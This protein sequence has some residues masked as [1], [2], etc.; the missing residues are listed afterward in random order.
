MKLY[1]YAFSQIICRLLIE[2]VYNINRLH[3]NPNTAS[4]KKVVAKNYKR[5]GRERCEIKLG[6]Q[7]LPPAV[8]KIK[9]FDNDDKA[10][11]H[12]FFLECFV[13]L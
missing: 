13:A 6:N 2:A 4:I 11:K 3:L 12:S 8:N 1:T 10:A 7:C 5:P 9:N